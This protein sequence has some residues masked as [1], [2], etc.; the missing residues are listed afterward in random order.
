[1]R[2]VD[3]FK[4]SRAYFFFFEVCIRTFKSRATVASPPV[5]PASA[6][7]I[8]SGDPLLMPRC[9]TA[10]AAPTTSSEETNVK[11]ILSALSVAGIPNLETRGM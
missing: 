2:A 5:A 9:V 4:L 3:H 10:H 8:L 7:L 1:M 11:N 6:N